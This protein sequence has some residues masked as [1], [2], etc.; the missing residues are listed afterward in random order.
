MPKVRIIGSLAEY[1]EY[2]E[3]TCYDDN[4][5]F[6]GQNVDKPLLPKIA[7][8]NLRGGDFLDVEARML[9]EFKRQSRPFLDPIPESDWDWV[10][11]AQ[12]HGMAT[13][14]LDWTT[15]P[16][17]ALWFAVYRPAADSGGAVVW[18]FEVPPKDMIK[19]DAGNN[20][21]S[22][23][24]TSVFR[25]NHVT[26]RIAAQSG[27]FTVHK[28]V[29]KTSRFVPL[30]TNQTYKASLTKVSIKPE[31]F[32]ELRFQL[33]RFGVNQA[34]LFPDLEGLSRHIEWSFSVMDDEEDIS[35]SKLPRKSLPKPRK[36][37]K[38]PKAKKAFRH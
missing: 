33:D 11:V 34:T 7:R 10:A 13:R 12:H 19:P 16:L 1:A 37:T 9:D 32:S 8:I 22:G 36:K 14:L 28:Y 29:T 24:R 35:G 3:E 26:Q 38:K 25:P 17:A 6:R 15:N 21:F 4:F 2:I 5:V 31:K 27:W 18:V 20:P 30:N 23:P